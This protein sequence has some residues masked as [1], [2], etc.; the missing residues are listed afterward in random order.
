MSPGCL[1]TY[2]PNVLLLAQS[3][4]YVLN[5][6]GWT[7][8]VASIGSVVTLLCFCLTKVLSLPPVDQEEVKGPLSIET[9]DT[10]DAD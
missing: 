1:L 3:N 9:G 8:M 7:V 10:D 4:E 6:W 5:G 2:L